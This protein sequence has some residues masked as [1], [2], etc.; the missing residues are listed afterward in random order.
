[1]I[2]TI[3]D[4][5]LPFIVG[6]E[7]L[8]ESYG[9]GNFHDSLVS[10]L[11][12][13]LASDCHSADILLSLSI[14][15]EVEITLKFVGVHGIEMNVPDTRSSFFDSVDFYVAQWCDYGKCIIMETDGDNLKIVADQII[16]N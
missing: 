12:Y 16:V 13:H 11:E 1:M 4:E 2:K 7:E 15:G 6:I 5:C 14:Y 9:Y 10:L 8:I 3:C